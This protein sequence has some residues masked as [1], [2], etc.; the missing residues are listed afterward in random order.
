MLR[1]GHTGKTVARSAAQATH[2]W[3]TESELRSEL[4]KVGAYSIQR[5]CI[6][7]YPYKDYIIRE[8]VGTYMAFHGI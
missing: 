1:L 7:S 3:E 2:A 6:R 8:N 4:H 5:T